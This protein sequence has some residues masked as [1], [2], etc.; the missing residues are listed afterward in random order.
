M[1]PRLWCLAALALLL[2]AIGCNGGGGGGLVIGDIEGPS[3]VAENSSFDFSI[4]VTGDTG[5]SYAWAVEPASAG[6]FTNQTSATTTFKATTVNGHLDA[7]IRVTVHS[8][9]FGPE[10]RSREIE[11]REVGNLT[12]S[13][14][15]GAA[16]VPEDSASVFSV[17]ADGDFGIEYE[18]T[19]DPSSAV[20]FTLPESPETTIVTPFIGADMPVTLTVTVTSDN[21]GP[22]TRSID[23]TILE[24]QVLEA[25]EIE[26]PGLI[27]E[28]F[29]S[30][31]SV[32][33]YG[34]SGI[35]YQW[36]VDPPSAGSFDDPTSATTHFTS[37][38]VDGEESA[39]I[40]VEM[41]SDFY[42]DVRKSVDI[43]VLDMPDYEWGV[44]Y[45]EDSYIYSDYMIIDDAGSMYTAGNFSG[46]ARFGPGGP[47][48]QAV[49][50]R[51]AYV[52]RFDSSGAVQWAVSWG[53]EYDDEPEDMAIDDSG[54]VYVIGT[55]A[56]Y[57]DFDPGPGVYYLTSG[58]QR[59]VYLL[60][61]DSYGRFRWVVSWGNSAYGDYVSNIVCDGAGN[62]W[63]Y[64]NFEG[65]V[66]FD[67]GPGIRQ[68][69]PA[70]DKHYD[71]YLSRFNSS[72]Q[73]LSVMTGDQSTGLD[74]VHDM[75][76]DEQGNLWFVGGFESTVD[77]DPGPG[78]DERSTIYYNNDAFL[79][80]LGPSGSYFGTATW[81]GDRGDEA[82][83]VT[84]GSNG[85]VF[86]CG[87]YEG[88]AD[89]DPGPGYDYR[90]DPEFHRGAF[91]SGFDS[92]LNRAFTQVWYGEGTVYAYNIE[93]D[94]LG[95]T[96]VMGTCEGPV[97]FDP[98]G[99]K[100]IKIHTPHEW[101]S[102]LSC[103]DASG[104]LRWNLLDTAENSASFGA[105]ALDAA[106]NLLMAN[107][108]NGSAD[109]D[110]TAGVDERNV[111]E[112]YSNCFIKLVP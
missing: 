20:S 44:K 71:F 62:T 87:E 11:I 89:F 26:G 63:I 28:G 99:R 77:F 96:Y 49:D 68:V 33:A 109:I 91:V 42:S 38:Q 84:T 61:L 43:E 111:G 15:S 56:R 29:P 35:A 4:E 80:K 67:P 108:F 105:Y 51:D 81:G 17:E 90:G 2:S 47:V 76:L 16:E 12:V 30:E 24:T 85:A 59:D 94:N 97:D 54:N 98:A 27:E 46:T 102:Y 22:V 92:N 31:Y 107:R 60:S 18:W 32:E 55:F 88:I 52:A 8:G 110:P 5:I 58:D 1:I 53:A 101:A 73:F 39:R 66:D 95:R 45:S 70:E 74:E 82:E 69:S 83:S 10:V 41:S 104:L 7:V 86:V 14:I 48:L 72:G 50:S 3:L 112:T 75:A 64:G 106:G 19:C 78:V 65:G 23:V 6:N 21:F 9:R 36:T 79:T 37:S 57:I 25:E 13:D 100:L 34:D 40:W 103:L 93:V